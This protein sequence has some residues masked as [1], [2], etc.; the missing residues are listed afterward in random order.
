MFGMGNNYNK[1]VD[2]WMKQ[3]YEDFVGSFQEKLHK[4]YIIFQDATTL[5]LK[6]IQ[7]FLTAFVNTCRHLSKVPCTVYLWIHNPIKTVSLYLHKIFPVHIL[8]NQ[9]IKTLF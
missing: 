3:T 8:T 2:L 5:K 1:F 9:E 6:L 7:P 4:I